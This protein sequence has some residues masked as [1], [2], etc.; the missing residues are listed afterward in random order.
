MLWRTGRRSHVLKA[1]LRE[2]HNV[3]RSKDPDTDSSVAQAATQ[4]DQLRKLRV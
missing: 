3:G 4:V 1:W 2:G